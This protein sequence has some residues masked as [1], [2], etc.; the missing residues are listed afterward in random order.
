M[1]KNKLISIVITLI[2]WFV[3]FY[4]ALPAINI[5]S[6]EFWSFTI[7]LIVVAV[8]I[9]SYSLIK[10]I[11][12]NKEAMP[13]RERLK[14]FKKVII[15][16]LAFV[17]IYGGGTL[18]SSP[19][20]RASAYKN[21]LGVQTSDFKE[22]IK[23]VNYSQIP[24]LDKDSAALLSERKM[25]SMIDM[26][27]QYEV[28]DYYTQ[29]NYKEK[30]MRVTP[31]EYGSII[32]WITN[33]STGIPAYVQ[34]DMASQDVELIKLK[35]GIT[36]S[37][38]EHFG[39]NLDRFLRFRYPTAMFRS[40]NFE[41]D[42]DGTPY[43][44]C[45][46]AT[47]KIGLFGGTDIKGA[48]LLNAIT[49]EHQYYDV[50]DVPTWV[51]KVYDAELLVQQYN[52][53][54][55]LTNG[56]LNSIFGQR[57]CLQTTEG[58]NYIAL[59]DD[60]WV[61]TGITSVTGDESIVGFVLMNQRTKET[62][63]YQTSGAKEISAMRSAEGQ[64]QHLGYVATFPL[65]LNVGG[66][67]SYFLALKDEAGLVKKYAMVNIEKYQIVAIG[68]SISECDKN[69]KLLLTDNGITTVPTKEEAGYSGVVENVWNV[70]IDGNTYYY[71]QLNNYNQLFEI[72]AKNDI[73][74]V[75]IAKGDTV[76]I[77]GYTEEK[78]GIIGIA[79]IE[80]T[81]LE[82]KTA[83]EVSK[84]MQK[85]ENVKQD[86]QKIVDTTSSVNP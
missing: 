81:K 76:A 12:E 36:I 44:I 34:I 22:D 68:D 40:K 62:K 23:E 41:V 38:S 45:P 77:Q 54:G 15:V 5:Q 16:I 84:P 79:T 72:A 63:Y 71:F 21:L 78:Q 32:K 74:V 37:P 42:D 39:R 57:G 19:I 26:V 3:M 50:G 18:L 24:L 69:Y 52:Y 82:T 65:L 86:T 80:I 67:P 55:V 47:K 2:V 73:S 58:Y 51:D 48:V 29:I 64:V 28:S 17:I 83:D 59:D 30:P 49:G 9:N 25:G 11:V 1:K 35:D 60:V 66:E 56:Y 75:K 13:L 46:V 20:I 10:S 33:R 14:Q 61:Y 8:V 70:V 43:W 7:S 85:P 27:S 53:H 6:Q 4:S 31:L